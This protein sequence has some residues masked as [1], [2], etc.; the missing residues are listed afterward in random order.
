[1]QTPAMTRFRLLLYG[2]MLAQVW[3]IS[4]PGIA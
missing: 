1:M 4:P 3:V 2:L